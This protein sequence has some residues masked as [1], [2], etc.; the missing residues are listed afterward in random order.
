MYFD[1]GYSI[2]ASLAPLT[3]DEIIEAALP[4]VITFDVARPR[5]DLYRIIESL[6]VSCQIR[7]RQVALSKNSTGMAVSYYRCQRVTD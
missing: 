4:T 2:Q 1:D 6:P 5:T 7:L 3:Q